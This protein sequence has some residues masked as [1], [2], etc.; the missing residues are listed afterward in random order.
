MIFKDALKAT[1]PSTSNSEKEIEKA[2][3]KYKRLKKSNMKE[4][5]S[6]K[7]RKKIFFKIGDKVVIR[8]NKRSSKFYKLYCLEPNEIIAWIEA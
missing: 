4:I 1:F 7:Y 8:N 5:N 3:L 6:S 2:I